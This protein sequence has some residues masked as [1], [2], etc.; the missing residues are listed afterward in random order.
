MKNNRANRQQFKDKE[1]GIPFYN[2]NTSNMNSIPHHNHVSKGLRIIND[3]PDDNEKKT[4][5]VIVT[6]CNA[7]SYDPLFTTVEQKALE[8][9]KVEVYACDSFYI[10]NM[11]NAF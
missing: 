4:V 11:I 7:G 9:T 1:V 8:G 10:E 2:L 3:K 5:A 6:F